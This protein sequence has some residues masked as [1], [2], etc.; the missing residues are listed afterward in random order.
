[1]SIVIVNDSA[2]VLEFPEESESVTV[3]LHTPSDNEP[4]VQV[5]EDIVQVTFA[6]PALDAVTLAVAVPKKLPETFIF[7][8][9]SLVMLSV[10][11]NP[12]SEVSSR[13]GFAG[14]EDSLLITT[15][16]SAVPASELT[17]PPD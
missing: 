5:L 1:M 3:R 15:L 10:L 4:N 13:S 17:P 16:P 2:D 9:S 12:K 14:I 7:G 11:D 8:V 6:A